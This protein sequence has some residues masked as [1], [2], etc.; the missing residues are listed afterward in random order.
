MFVGC[1]GICTLEREREKIY[2]T[3]T[4]CIVYNMYTH[5]YKVHPENPSMLHSAYT[6]T[7]NTLVSLKDFQ[8][9][10]YIHVYT[11]KLYML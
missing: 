6:C 10:L 2:T 8:D 3:C 4:T 11:C 5:V 7:H 9:V 1:F